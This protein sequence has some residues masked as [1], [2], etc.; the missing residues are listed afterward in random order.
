MTFVKE[1]ERILNCRPLTP[2]SDDPEDFSCLSPMSILNMYLA[3]SLSLGEFVRSD[4]LRKSWK[5]AQLMT[6]HF[7]SA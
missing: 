4:G 2:L 6:D 3:P 1:V 7:C 5:A